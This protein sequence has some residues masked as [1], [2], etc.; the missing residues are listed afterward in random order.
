VKTSE[1]LMDLSFHVEDL[2][3]S[4]E[5]SNWE[6]QSVPPAASGSGIQDLKFEI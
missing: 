6:T 2:K 4:P 1:G 3:Q 5:E